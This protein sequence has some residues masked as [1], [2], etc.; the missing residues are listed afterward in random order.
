MKTDA[1]SKT[2]TVGEGRPPKMRGSN[3]TYAD[4]YSQLSPGKFVQAT[5][6]VD[7]KR[8]YSCLAWH[9]RTKKLPWRIVRNSHELRLYVIEAEG[10]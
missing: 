2:F 7:L 6:L 4:I 3:S 5:S 8:I 10:S 9:V 1:L